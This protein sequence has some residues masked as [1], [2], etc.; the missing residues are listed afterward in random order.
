MARESLAQNNKLSKQDAVAVLEGIDFFT[1]TEAKSWMQNGT[2]E[3]ALGFTAGI[4]AWTGQMNRPLPTNFRGQ[5]SS[6]FISKAAQNTHRL[7]QLVRQSDP[8]LADALVGNKKASAFKPQYQPLNWVGQ[9]VRL[10][11]KFESSS[12]MLTPQGKQVLAVLAQELQQF[13]PKTTVVKVVGHTSVA[14]E[15]SRN[16]LLSQQRAEVVANYLRS[17][18]NLRHQISAMGKGS[19]LALPGINPNDSRNQ[20]TEVVVSKRLS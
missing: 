17:R 6:E 16:Q 18:Y 9:K 19:S 15:P 14:G 20:R 7:I 11:V 13:D 2:L 12:A 4:L 10:E 8:S 5:Y 3:K 1:A